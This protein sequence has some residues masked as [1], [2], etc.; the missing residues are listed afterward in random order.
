MMLTVPEKRRFDATRRL[1]RN[2][3]RSGRMHFSGPG[4]NR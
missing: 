3:R 2:V 4:N 1:A